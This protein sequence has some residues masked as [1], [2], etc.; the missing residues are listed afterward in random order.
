[1]MKSHRFTHFALPLWLVICFGLLLSSSVLAQDI[2]DVQR[3]HGVELQAWLVNNQWLERR[4]KH[5]VL[6]SMS[7]LF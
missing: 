3:K 7:K 4:G 6:A 5:Q 2:R 1:M